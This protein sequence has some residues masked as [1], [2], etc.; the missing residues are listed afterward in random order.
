MIHTIQLDRILQGAVATPY[1]D[2]VTRPT[3]AEVRSRVEVSISEAH[4]VTALLDFSAVGLLDF[5]CADEVVAKLLL[6]SRSDEGHVLLMGLSEEQS[7]AID[8]VLNNHQLVVA[9]LPR[10]GETPFLLGATSPEARNAFRYVHEMGPC[11]AHD[12][13]REM[14]WALSLALAALEQLAGHR[15]VQVDRDCYRPIPLQ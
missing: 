13:A 8:H 12:L 5:S 14:S 3:G 4:C 7:E 15:L 1:R 10:P 6:R 2:L 11:T 9:V